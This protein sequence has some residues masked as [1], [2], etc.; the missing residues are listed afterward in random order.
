MPG[1]GFAER[2]GVG[3]EHTPG[4]L[5]IVERGPFGIEDIGEIRM[6][7]VALQEALFLS[8]A[9]FSGSII[10]SRNSDQSSLNVWT[11]CLLIFDGFRCKE[12]STQHFSSIFFPN[13][14]DQFLALAAENVLQFSHDL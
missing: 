3:T 14:L 2:H 12:A 1:L 6:K 5:E 13:G 8:L 11:K 4:A 10:E 7:R 9:L